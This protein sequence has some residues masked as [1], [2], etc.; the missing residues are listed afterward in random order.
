M[1][2]LTAD[3]RN[4]SQVLLPVSDEIEG[5]TMEFVDDPDTIPISQLEK[6]LIEMEGMKA[7]HLGYIYIFPSAQCSNKPVQT[8]IAQSGDVTLVNE[9]KRKTTTEH[10]ANLTEGDAY[11]QSDISDTNQLIDASRNYVQSTSTI[12]METNKDVYDN[13]NKTS[14]TGSFRTL[15][16]AETQTDPMQPLLDS[17]VHPS[18][19]EEQ[20]LRSSSDTDTYDIGGK[21]DTT[22]SSVGCIDKPLTKHSDVS[23]DED[24]KLYSPI[25]AADD[26]EE[27]DNDSFESMSEESKDFGDT[28]KPTGEGVVLYD[29]PDDEDEATIIQRKES[30]NIPTTTKTTF[31]ADTDT[32]RDREKDKGSDLS[33]DDNRDEISEAQLLVAEPL[34][35]T[36][37]GTLS[38]TDTI[39]LDEKSIQSC[40]TVNQ[41]NQTDEIETSEKSSEMEQL[42]AKPVQ[43]DA[44]SQTE[45]ICSEDHHSQTE[46][47]SVG[48]GNS[49]TENFTI[50]ST[51]SQTDDVQVGSK[52]SQ[53]TTI[54]VGNRRSQVT[55]A[56]DVYS[57]TEPVS[58]DRQNTQTEPMIDETVPLG[59]APGSRAPPGKKKVSEQ[60]TQTDL[61]EKM[62]L[63]ILSSTSQIHT[64]SK[65]SAEGISYD[66]SGYTI[67]IQSQDQPGAATEPTSKRYAD[68]HSAASPSS[69]KDP[70]EFE[71]GRKSSEGKLSMKT[72]LKSDRHDSDK[73]F[74]VSLD[75]SP[76]GNMQFP[77]FL[78]GPGEYG[79]ETGAWGGVKEEV[80][81]SDPGGSEGFLPDLISPDDRLLSG[82]PGGA[83]RES[84]DVKVDERDEP[85]SGAF[86]QQQGRCT[87]KSSSK[88][89][90]QHKLETKRSTEPSQKGIGFV[91]EA[92]SGGDS[93]AL[94]GEMSTREIIIGHDGEGEEES[95]KPSEESEIS[96][97]T[98]ETDIA[99]RMRRK[100]QLPVIIRYAEE[101]KVGDWCTYFCRCCLPPYVL[102][103]LL[104]ALACLLPLT[105]PDI[106]CCFE[107]HYPST[108]GIK[109][110]YPNGPPPI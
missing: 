70:L 102:F 103:L 9:F 51:D 90:I 8:D 63:A 27:S 68:M 73:Q 29:E 91:S 23:V 52:Y 41:G 86:G 104:L 49:Q 76:E 67:A 33:R 42:K 30:G 3:V 74:G 59:S 11:L 1:P 110:T 57:Q 21:D 75:S 100:R 53:T 58:Q 77:D 38:Q 48:D 95:A 89:K 50:K 36:K 78:D 46:R 101:E 96:S 15:V 66:S 85:Q 20:K 83:E 47:F 7:T 18:Q 54:T 44:S 94:A 26:N 55:S 105:E 69:V 81:P 39:S 97:L 80:H 109:M 87:R 10:Q 34:F 108:F 106:S 71:S 4:A 56:T 28:K 32:R 79:A 19:V 35:L 24:V 93:V 6:I 64:S 65:S 40:Q 99:L 82:V 98:T 22:I 45:V 60:D 88:R 72:S 84:V 43:T 31:L 5:V 16:S 17:F 62:L 12:S 2:E 14:G 25:D 61:T 13:N 92:P 107:N 37:Q